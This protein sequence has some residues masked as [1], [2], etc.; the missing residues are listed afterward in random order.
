MAAVVLVSAFSI[1]P[2][3][4]DAAT[5]VE[6]LVGYH[7]SLP[8]DI[9]ARF[10]PYGVIVVDMEGRLDVALVRASSES[11]IL[12]AVENDTSVAYVALNTLDLFSLG[13]VDPL[14]THQWGIPA[15]KADVAWERVMGSPKITL[16]V[17]DSGIDVDHPDLAANL[18]VDPQT[19]T[20][21]YDFVNEQPWPHD[22]LGHGTHVTGIAAAAAYNGQG[23]AGVAQVKIMAVKIFNDAGQPTTA[24]KVAR[25]MLWAVEH[26][27]D[28]ML[29]SSGQP[30][31]H[32]LLRA[33]AVATTTAG[34]V[35]VASAGN[36]GGQVLYPAQ[37]PE[38][39]A[40]GATRQDGTLWTNSN[41]GS[42]FEDRRYHVEVVAPGVDIVATSNSSLQYVTTYGTC[43]Y[44][45]YCTLT[46]TSQAAA[47]AAGVA[48]LIRSCAPQ[49]PA[50]R[51]RATLNSTTLDLGLQGW[52]AETG[53]GLLDAAKAA[54]S[55]GSYVN[56][57]TKTCDAGSTNREKLEAPILDDPLRISMA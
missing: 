21:G 46:G 48:S 17:L 39:I 13:D 36:D 41:R 29:F 10:A 12:S 32:P 55:A 35:V 5:M 18:W 52:D 57:D 16:A 33:A 31:D 51:V 54:E 9:D 20:P 14:L 2:P 11:S 50:D 49:M 38:V 4:A 1:L 6:R 19:G 45:E 40:V 53:Y 24:L 8:T 30:K 42:D 56:P 34:T 7:D 3:A 27:A 25:A 26:G 37:Y 44:V 47:F 43:A 28:V 15:I 22:G 23:I